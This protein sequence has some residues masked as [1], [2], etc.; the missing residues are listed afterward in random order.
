VIETEQL[1]VDY[2]RILGY[3]IDGAVEVQPLTEVYITHHL[4]LSKMNSLRFQEAQALLDAC[5]ERL[6]P[7]LSSNVDLYASGAAIG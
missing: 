6:L 7:K 5:A 3:I 4:M 2:R 1:A